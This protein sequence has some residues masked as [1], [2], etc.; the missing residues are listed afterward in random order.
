M[1]QDTADSLCRAGLLT[2]CGPVQRDLPLAVWNSDIGVVFNQK[3]YVL[4]PVIKCRPVQSSLLQREKTQ[5]DGEGGKI[6]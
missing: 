1:Y 5:R 3:A 4:R 2:V 6:S